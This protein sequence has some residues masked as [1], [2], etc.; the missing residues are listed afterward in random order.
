MILLMMEMMMGVVMAIVRT[1]EEAAKY[2]LLSEFLEMIETT[3][4]DCM[5]VDTGSV[6]KLEQKDLPLFL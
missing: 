3:N 1:A 5:V 4:K 2:G 6:Y